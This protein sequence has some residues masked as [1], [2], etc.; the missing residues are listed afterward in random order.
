MYPP[1]W[2]KNVTTWDLHYVHDR[3]P[4]ELESEDIC[5]NRRFWRL[6]PIPMEVFCNYFEKKNEKL[7]KLQERKTIHTGVFVLVEILAKCHTGVHMTSFPI[8]WAFNTVVLGLKHSRANWRLQFCGYHPIH[9]VIS[10]LIGSSI[11][12]PALFSGF[13][14][15]QYI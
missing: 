14:W 2:S 13:D 6:Q 8:E 15:Q 12:R 10:S 4:D 9:M 11:L 3:S 5:K 7:S 1:V